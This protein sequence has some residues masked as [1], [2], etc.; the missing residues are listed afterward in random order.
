MFLKAVKGSVVVSVCMIF[1]QRH[2][3][4]HYVTYQSIATFFCSGSIGYCSFYLL[5]FSNASWAVL[6]V[7][8]CLSIIAYLFKDKHC[9]FGA[10]VPSCDI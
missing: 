6:F 8:L 3:A 2:Q 1:S 5:I 9:Y 7:L 4:S 10:I